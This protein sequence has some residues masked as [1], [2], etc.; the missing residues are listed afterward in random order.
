MNITRFEPQ[1]QAWG[2][3]VVLFISSLEYFIFKGYILDLNLKTSTAPNYDTKRSY[4]SIKKFSCEK[5][6]SLA[7]SIN[8]IQIQKQMIRGRQILLLFKRKSGKKGDAVLK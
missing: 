8:N 2:Q 7:R 4:S 6:N 5:K 1:K 3:I